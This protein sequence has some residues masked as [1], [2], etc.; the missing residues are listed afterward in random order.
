MKK[1][2]KMNTL[3][4]VT[5]AVVLG[6]AAGSI[7][8]ASEL[9]DLFQPENFERFQEKEQPQNY[10]YVAGDGEDV[11]LA[12]E[13][14]NGEDQPSGDEQQVLQAETEQT[15]AE[16]SLK[17]AKKNDT[18]GE[19]EN[20]NAAEL[21]PDNGSTNTA[22]PNGQA[23]VPS[24]EQNNGNNGQKTQGN[25]TKPGGQTDD[26]ANGTGKESEKNQNS[27]NGSGTDKDHQ[28]GQTGGNTGTDN[29]KTDTDKDHNNSSGTESRDEDQ[30]KPEDPIMTEYGQLLSLKAQMNTSEFLMKDSWKAEY[31]TVTARF[32]KSDGSKEEKILSYDASG[33]KGYKVDFCTTSKG[34]QTAIFD[35]QGMTAKA[36]YSVTEKSVVPC[37]MAV[38]DSQQGSYYSESFPGDPLKSIL[39]SGF[40]QIKGLAQIP[41]NF[42]T[43]GHIVNLAE[44]HRCMIAYLGD[45]QIRSTFQN[46]AGTFSNIVFLQTDENGFLTNLLTGF[47]GVER[48]TLLDGKSYVYYPEGE[49]GTAGRNVLNYVEDIDPAEYKIRRRISGQPDSASYRG[50]QVLVGAGGN[51]EV[52]S[53]PTGV[54]T[55]AMEYLS[56]S[57]KVIELPESVQSV[58]AF[59]IAENLPNLEEYRYAQGAK[60]GLAISG[61]KIEDGILY[62]A[63]GKTLISVPPA[64]KEV[65]VPK[66]VTTLG[67]GCFSGMSEDSVI[68]FESEEAPKL[69]GTTGLTGTVKVPSSRYDLVRKAYKFA[70]AEE[71]DAIQFL[72]D[73]DDTDPY[74]Y[75]PH[76]PV[77][78]GTEDQQCLAA[79]PQDSVGDY[80]LTEETGTDDKSRSRFMI[81]SVGTAAFAGCEKLIDIEIGKQVVYLEEGSLILPDSVKNIRLESGNIQISP[82]V[83]GDPKEGYEVPDIR[84]YVTEDYE[85]CLANWTDTLDPVYGEG[86]AAKLLAASE[87]TYFNEDGARYQKTETT[88]GVTYRLVRV[89]RKNRTYMCV[90]EGTTEIA[91]DAFEGCENLEILVLPDSVK[92]LPDTDWTDCTVLEHVVMQAADADTGRS[93]TLPDQT[94]LLQAQKDYPE[95]DCE[96]G[97]LYGKH[98][99]GSWT[100]LNVPTDQTDALT[101]REET[102]ELAEAAM[103]DCTSLETVTLKEP[104][105]LRRIGASAF[106]NCA[107]TGTLDL[108]T[109]ISLRE[110]GS[111]TFAN[112]DN[113]TQVV[114]PDKVTVLKSGLF[115]DAA[116]LKEVSAVGTVQIEDEVFSGCTQFVDVKTSGQVTSI[117]KRAFYGCRKLQKIHLPETITELGES[118]FTNC[119]SLE[120][121]DIDGTLTYIGR[122]CFLGCEKLKTVTFSERVKSS[123]RILGVQAFAGCTS[124][125]SMDL[126]EMQALELIGN[127]TFKED[128]ELTTVRFP[129]SLKKIPDGC[130]AECVNLS[131]LQLTSENITEAG[132]RIFGDNLPGFLHIWV[133]EDMLEKYQNAYEPILD[134]E[135]GEGTARTVFGIVNEKIELIKGVLFENTEEGKVLKEAS[136]ELTGA[137][138]V[139]ADVV[140]IEEDAF[141]GCN[142]I[143][144]LTIQ[145]GSSVSLGDRCMK[146]CIGLQKLE[147]DGTVPQ[148][149]EETFMN[150]TSLEYVHF[151]GQTSTV[152]ERIGTRAF[153]GCTGLSMEG[154]VGFTTIIHEFGEECFADCTNL[155]SFSNTEYSRA[156]L[157]VIEDRVFENCSKLRVFLTTKYTGLTSIGAYAFHNC[158]TLAAPSVPS[159]VTSLGEGCFMDCDNITTVSI[160]G[161]VAEYPKNCFRN[162]VK[163]DRTAGTAAAYNALKRIGES[164]YEGCVS[165][166][167]QTTKSPWYLEKYTNLESIGARAFY[168]CKTLPDTA[169]SEHINKI[170]DHAFDGC[171]TMKTLTLKTE[172]PPELGACA[173]D[174]MAENF[175]ILVPDSQE[176]E[177]EVYLRYLSYLTDKYGKE[178]ALAILDSISDGARQ[179]YLTELAAET[180]TETE[181]ETASEAEA[182]SESETESETRPADET[183]TRPETETTSETE[184][185]SEEATEAAQSETESESAAAPETDEKSSETVK[186]EEQTEKESVKG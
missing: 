38:S 8:N 70:F 134:P 123:L 43:A 28:G 89:Y 12:D 91:P 90:K 137:Y 74:E 80:Q 94:V 7:L 64:R 125:E 93:S 182:E 181:T 86:T 110:V 175:S 156:G 140:R 39:G 184:P 166:N 76:G 160:Y 31:A 130:F 159:G 139:P 75:Q 51:Q 129:K 67:D 115:K 150:C 176:Q 58:D 147:I 170:G 84:V 10:D 34:A 61:Y 143:T 169:L 97:I 96:D 44:I 136:T 106:E 165:L 109:C 55:V 124:L 18:A 108:E 5:G 105:A 158:D 78:T 119:I 21:T 178:R 40:D 82:Y 152:I 20:K 17:I 47:R 71:C 149:G 179:R 19:S 81:T 14:Q 37:Y 133:E 180:D 53:V 4:V 46:I 73:T 60:N 135:Y 24:D 95:F 68:I 1:W 79:V 116:N 29:G 30:L 6:A 9:G 157:Q 77:L 2:I 87:I 102:V 151:D 177:D 186:S 62:S 163:L 111:Q 85:T 148:W 63:D 32:Q 42:V 100:L 173:F 54:T 52:L 117:G 41:N 16:N 49:W 66:E 112:C 118:C 167:L 161:A 22:K 121:A 168:G 3:K 138:N 172:N 56:D 11:D 101:I 126:T 104:E 120:Q 92:E 13:N 15:E 185:A 155:P 171:V 98:D 72:T 128:T 146:G 103:K 145:K 23:V 132:E 35:Y 164:A 69:E 33:K 162:C 131:I 88:Q 50:D 141:A 144:E 114:L 65:T 122:Y 142:Q 27:D 36:Q 26:S 83:F 48:H 153:K 127:E 25:G 45:E 107:V 113:L 174:K 183:K 154:A 57:T 59:D 99:D